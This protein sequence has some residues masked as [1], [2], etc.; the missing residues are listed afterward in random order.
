MPIG[1][2]EAP[3]FDPR[4]R[5]CHLGFDPAAQQL[6]GPN[7]LV[8]FALGGV[9]QLAGD[10]VDRAV[11]SPDRVAQLPQIHTNNSSEGV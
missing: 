2:V 3:L 1:Q 10:V 11:A 5:Q 9:D 7:P 8:E 4:Q 6:Q